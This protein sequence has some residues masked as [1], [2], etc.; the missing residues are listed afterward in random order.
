M[1]VN[2]I[3]TL[4]EGATLID[5]CGVQQ[6]PPQDLAEAEDMLRRVPPELEKRRTAFNVACEDLQMLGNTQ[7]ELRAEHARGEAEFQPML[8]SGWVETIRN[9]DACDVL[10]LSERLRP[11]EYKL[12]FMRDAKDLLVHKL[13]PAAKLHMLE[14]ALS[15]RKI[16]ELEGDLLAVI[17]HERTVQKAAGVFAEE[18]RVAIVGER[19]QALRKHAAEAARRVA[20]AEE[21]LR[22]ERK[23][24]LTEEQQRF[25]CHQ[26]TRAEAVAA[27][28]A[29]A[30]LIA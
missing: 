1:L 13:I 22:E 27:I 14:S 30:T 23:R 15:L 11:L 29:C 25:S 19:T 8:M 2:A 17:S 24:Q 28:P 10:A 16:E 18:G 26:I 21:E 12:A 20:L 9:L 5:L 6:S 4:P 7:G 3:S